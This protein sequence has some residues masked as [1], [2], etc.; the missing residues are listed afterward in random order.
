MSQNWLFFSIIV[1]FNVY[2]RS[3]NLSCAAVLTPATISRTRISRTAKN[4][5]KISIFEIF[6]AWNGH[7][8]QFS[9]KVGLKIYNAFNYCKNLTKNFNILVQKSSKKAQKFQFYS[10]VEWVTFISIFEISSPFPPFSSLLPL[11]KSLFGEKYLLGLK[12]TFLG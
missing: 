7:L 11:N 9:V 4:A 2:F 5:M 1:I 8:F 10:I 3:K 6:R 12:S